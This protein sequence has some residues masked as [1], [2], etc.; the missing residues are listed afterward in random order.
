MRAGVEYRPGSSQLDLALE[1]G[2]RGWRVLPMHAIASSECTCREAGCKHPGKHP[3]LKSWQ[4]IAT[5]R[6]ARIRAWWQQWPDANVGVLTGGKVGLLVLDVDPRTGGDLSLLAVER[7]C[8]RLPVTPRSRT[9]TGGWHYWFTC[10]P[11]VPSRAGALGPGLDI[12][13]RA[14][15]VTAPPSV[16][17][18]QPYAWELSPEA[19][20]LAPFP[21]VLVALLAHLH[22]RPLPPRPSLQVIG[23][24]DGLD[25]YGAAALRAELEDLTRAVEGQRNHQLNRAAFNMGQLIAAGALPRPRVEAALE[26]VALQRGLGLGETRRTIRRGLDAGLL[27]PR[28]IESRENGRPRVPPAALDRLIAEDFRGA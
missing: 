23:S 20:D 8:G 15:C 26:D 22:A 19:C 17:R 9:G 21:A 16:G 5:S 1:Y 14:G 28:V 27:R 10:W 18:D 6:S 11:D 25:A 7:I 12:K 24:P 3:R 13:S 4:R 2:A